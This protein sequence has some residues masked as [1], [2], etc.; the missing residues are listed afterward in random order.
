MIGLTT[1]Y[2]AGR[3]KNSAPLQG[4]WCWYF[5]ARCK[6]ALPILEQAHTP[7]VRLGSAGHQQRNKMAQQLVRSPATTLTTPWWPPSYCPPTQVACCCATLDL[8]FVAEGIALSAPVVN[9]SLPPASLPGISLTLPALGGVTIGH[10]IRAY[11][12]HLHS[13]TDGSDETLEPG[14]PQNIVPCSCHA[15]V[16]TWQSLPRTLALYSLN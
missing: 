1:K 15:G 3:A 14:S 7:V 16:I 13:Y 10:C 2:I 4:T 5:H 6:L 11:G 9:R 8:I 12:A